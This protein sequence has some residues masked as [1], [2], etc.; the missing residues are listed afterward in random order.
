MSAF[1]GKADMARA[2]VNVCF[3]PKADIRSSSL[4]LC[5]Y[6]SEPHFAGGK[7]LM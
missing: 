7:S 4:L 2:L 5:N 1:G 3:C 6:P